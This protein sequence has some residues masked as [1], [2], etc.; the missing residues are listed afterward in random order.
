MR[1]DPAGNLLPKRSRRAVRARH[2]L[3]AA[4]GLAVLSAAGCAGSATAGGTVS[5]TITIAAVPGVE[6]APLYLAKKEGLFA[7]AGLKNVVIKSYRSQSAELSAL[8]GGQVD[9]AASDYGNIFYQQSQSHGLRILADGYDAGPGVLEVLTLPPAPGSGPAIKSPVDLANQTIGLPAE[10]VLHGLLG[11]GS[12]ISLDAA[13][14]TQVLTNYLGNNAESVTWE[15]MSQQAEV[16]QLEQHKLKAILVGEPYI[17]EAE[18]QAGATVVLDACSGSTASLPLA[19]YVAMSPWVKDNQGAV[20][21]FQQAIARAE[22]DAS[23]TGQVQQLLPSA[24]GMSVQDADLITIGSYP[25]TTSILSLERVV[26]LMSNFNM[27]TLGHAP[28]VPPMVVH[29]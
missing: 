9:I 14:A 18:S 22:S 24:T 16:K 15:P 6:N 25:T 20:A 11:S 7:A 23:M 3:A 8:Q 28:N 5:G 26:R 21:D 27:I 10:S 2:L 13:A 17:Y 12:P 19:G 1:L 29:G 4:S